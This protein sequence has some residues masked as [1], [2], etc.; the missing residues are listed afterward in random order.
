MPKPIILSPMEIQIAVL[1]GGGRMNSSLKK[2]SR[3]AH[4]YDGKSPWDIHIEG[5]AAE[6]AYCKALNI[7]W[8][9]T[10]GTFGAA[11]VGND[12]QIRS[13]KIKDGCLV[14]READNSDQYYILVVGQIPEFTV[15]GWIHGK[16]AKQ[17]RW[18]RAPG[19]REAAYFI[20]QSELTPFEGV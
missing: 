5:A 9:G 18:L 1:V 17:V 11:D 6:M 15:I 8:A 10:V 13:T 16:A 20:P 19:G 4:G 14:V 12:V 2:H 7:Y 3:D